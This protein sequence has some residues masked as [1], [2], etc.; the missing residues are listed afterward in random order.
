MKFKEF[1]RKK[2]DFSENLILVD[3]EGEFYD[4]IYGCSFDT[5]LKVTS[6][7]GLLLFLAV[8]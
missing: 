8:I 7:G 2:Q 3:K 4:Y 6:S 1:K 5:L